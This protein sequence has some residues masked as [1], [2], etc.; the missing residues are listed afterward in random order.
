MPEK[1]ISRRSA[2][3][4]PID[5]RALE[6]EIDKEIDALLVP[7]IQKAQN[8]A[9]RSK[10]TGAA[11]NFSAPD[12]GLQDLESSAG[13]SRNLDFDG[14]RTA[15]EKEIDSLFI[16]SAEYRTR[17]PA[18]TETENRKH[19][20]QG[21]SPADDGKE[22]AT[23]TPKDPPSAKPSRAAASGEEFD[24]LRIAI[25]KEIDN[26][27]VPSAEYRDQEP[28]KTGHKK[29]RQKMQ[30]MP[31]AEDQKES[32]TAP[33]KGS[34][35]AKPSRTAA[36]GEGFDD[37]RIAIDKEIDNLFVPSAEYRD[38]EPVKTGHK[39]ARQKMQDILPAEDEKQSV[40][41]RKQADPS[42]KPSQEAASNEELDDLRAAVE[43][44]I[45]NLFVPAAEYRDQEPVKTSHKKGRQKM[46]DM[47]P[48]ED[49]KQSVAARKKA[50][51]SSK[52]LPEASSSEEFIDLQTAVEKEIDNLFVP[53]ADEK[54]SIS[55]RKEADPSSEPS[56]EAASNKKSDDLRVAI[57]KEIDNLFVPAAEYRDLEPVETGTEELPPAV[58]EMFPVEDGQESAPVPDKTCTLPEFSPATASGE[59]SDGLRLKIQKELE[60]LFAPAPEYRNMEPVETGTEEHTPPAQDM[61]PVADG[62]ESAQVPRL[63]DRL[64]EPSPAA[65]SSERFD[66]RRLEMQTDRFPSAEYREEGPVSAGSDEPEAEARGVS[67]ASDGLESAPARKKDDPSPELSAAQNEEPDDSPTAE[68]SFSH[69]LTGLIEGFNAAYLSLDWE[70]SKEN[71]RKFLAAL[72]GLEPFAAKSAETSS[73]HRLMQVIIKRLLDRPHA[74]NSVLV[75]LI[76]DSQRLLARL[77]LTEKI[78]PHE[79][80]QIQELFAR[81]NDLRQRALAAKTGSEK[82]GLEVRPKAAV[83]DADKIQSADEKSPAL[84][85]S[86][87]QTSPF[88]ELRDWMDKIRH[89]LSENL[90]VFDTEIARIRQIETTLGST[91]DLAPIART[92]SGVGNALEARVEILRGNS[93]ELADWASRVAR[94]EA[95]HADVNTGTRNAEPATP[96]GAKC[97]KTDLSAYKGSLYLIESHGKCLALPAGC[98]LKVARTKRGDKILKRGYATIDDFRPFFLRLIESGVLGKWVK[99]PGKE[100]DS[101]RFEPVE[102][103]LFGH[104]EKCGRVAVLASD[105]SRH[106]VIFADSADLISDPQ[107]VAKASGNGDL[108]ASKTLQELFPLAFDPGSP[109]SLPD[110]VLSTTSATGPCRR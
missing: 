31:P 39:K 5:L 73:V 33:P 71:I 55:V 9:D 3:E 81:F 42:S 64:Q 104:R 8:A 78:G 26:L 16:P 66:G 14:L 93:G 97:E 29:T 53:A 83:A 100:L 41:A 92:L 70:L 43:K 28:V 44:E 20:T 89:S 77:L 45:D 74:V 69:E 109:V 62:Q 37:L 13:K 79:K 94:L 51:S 46:Q 90:K 15:I 99:R 7:A 54:Q 23:T 6:L 52:P 58:Q 75:Q 21:A 84:P 11:R 86:A 65:E 88:D 72:N 27:F 40:S 68:L 101:Y 59:M 105:G 56:P 48:A 36:S 91:A 19:E 17:E 2:A 110:Q 85:S 38:Q 10:T 82:Q 30:G 22:S 80:K 96:T 32:A 50:G 106:A 1:D 87:A 49:E 4:P 95:A 98:V 18:R 108:S 67:A 25:E 24:D 60:N 34:P 107:A 76:R 57:E 35:S 103:G 47:L 102:P 63:E 61:S 12:T